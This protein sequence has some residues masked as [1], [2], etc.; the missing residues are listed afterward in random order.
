[1]V[2]SD[3]SLNPDADLILGHVSLICQTVL[4]HDGKHILTADRDEHIRVSRYP[5]AFVIDRYL[6]GSEG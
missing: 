4:T 5:Q 6:W 1:M 3:P 2:A